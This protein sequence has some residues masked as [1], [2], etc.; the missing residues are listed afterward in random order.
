MGCDILFFT[1]F[2][3]CFK[4]QSTQPEWAATAAEFF[5]EVPG[6][7]SI[8]AARVGC[9]MDGFATAEFGDISIHAARV[10]CDIFSSTACCTAGISIHAARV[11]CDSVLYAVNLTLPTF[12]STQPEWAAT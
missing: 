9:D 7:I 4:F 11:G 1:V 6:F 8:H 2:F 10:G 5:Y 12:Q 3:G